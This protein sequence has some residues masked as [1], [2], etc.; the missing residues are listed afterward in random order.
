VLFRVRV[1]KRAY[2]GAYWDVCGFEGVDKLAYPKK[3]ERAVMEKKM[4]LFRYS[5][6]V[7]RKN[8]RDKNGLSPKTNCSEREK[9][10]KKMKFEIKRGNENQSDYVEGCNQRITHV[11]T[12]KCTWSSVSQ[13]CLRVNLKYQMV[14]DPRPCHGNG[15]SQ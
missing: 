9:Y 14:Y 3:L 2:R 7:L 12:K 11:R 6:V 5:A 8:K 4:L 15:S 10:K 1:W 13:I